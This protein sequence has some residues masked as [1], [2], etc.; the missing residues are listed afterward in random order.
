[1]SQWLQSAVLVLSKVQVILTH[2]LRSLVSQLCVSAELFLGSLGGGALPSADQIDSA[3][4]QVAM[5]EALLKKYDVSKN[6][7]SEGKLY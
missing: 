1:M 6:I 4:G 5:L 7:E 3:H 2:V